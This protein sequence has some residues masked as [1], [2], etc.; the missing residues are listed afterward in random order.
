MFKN[1]ETTLVE[2][3]IVQHSKA[4]FIALL[5][6]IR[7]VCKNLPQNNSLAYFSIISFMNSDFLN[8]DS[9]LCLQSYKKFGV[10]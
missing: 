9:C 10:N 5:A 6:N 3:L 1:F 8:I 4:E 2:P 7:L